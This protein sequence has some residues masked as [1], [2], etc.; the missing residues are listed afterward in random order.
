MSTVK[1]PRTFLEMATTEINYQLQ[2]YEPDLNVST[3]QNIE[4]IINGIDKDDKPLYEQ[5]LVNFLVKEYKEFDI[6]ELKGMSSIYFVYVPQFCVIEGDIRAKLWNRLT[7]LATT[8]NDN[9]LLGVVFTVF[10][11]ISRDKASVNSLVNEEWL[12]LVIENIGLNDSSFNYDE[13]TLCKIEEGQ[14]VLWNTLFNSKE[15]VE[16]SVSNGVVEKLINRIKY[17]RF[18]G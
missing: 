8:T 3:K 5:A 16:K 6:V 9:D 1:S 13:D 4:D 12:S 15:L 7:N 17:V 10:R 11:I 14:K 18:N 2:H